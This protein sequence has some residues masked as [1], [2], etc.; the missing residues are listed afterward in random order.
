MGVSLG[1]RME[2]SF[3]GE[4]KAFIPPLMVGMPGWPTL[5]GSRRDPL[6]VGNRRERKR[7]N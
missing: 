2:D 1:S 6:Q 3:L 4:T 5:S 7:A